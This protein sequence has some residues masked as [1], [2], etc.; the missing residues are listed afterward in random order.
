M[1]IFPILAFL[2][3]AVPLLEIFLFIQVGGWIGV[4]PTIGLVIVTAIAGA[5]LLRW[6]GLATLSRVR[7]ALD[8]GQIPALEMLEGV[9]LVF[10]GALLLTPGFFTDAIGFA[11]LLPLTRHLMARWLFIKGVFVARGP[12]PG[13]PQG[14]AG[15]GESG[16]RPGVGGPWRANTGRTTPSEG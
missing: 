2:F 10:G 1:P 8:Q 6:Q 3:L 9:L 11:C 16:P 13:G 7:R 15:P 14:P 5:F 12:R 4:W